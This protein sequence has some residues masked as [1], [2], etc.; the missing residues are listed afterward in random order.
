[1]GA[2]P[3][4]HSHFRLSE[5]KGRKLREGE[6]KKGYGIGKRDRKNRKSRKEEEKEDI[7]K[8]KGR[9]EESDREKQRFEMYVGEKKRD[10][11]N[12]KRRKE[13]EEKEKEIENS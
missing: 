9:E 8:M 13:K 7:E 10:R 1:M 4:Q 3:C 5:E 11:K 6:I 12:I 2:A